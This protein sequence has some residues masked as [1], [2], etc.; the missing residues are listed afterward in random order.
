MGTFLMKGEAWWK[1]GPG[2][3]VLIKV[4]HFINGSGKQKRSYKIE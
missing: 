1:G 2:K 3:F 4:R